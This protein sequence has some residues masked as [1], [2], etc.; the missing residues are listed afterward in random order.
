MQQPCATLASAAFVSDVHLSADDP[1]TANAFLA[2]LEALAG[3]VQ[4]LFVLGDLFDAWI[5]DDDSDAAFAAQVHSAF[6]GL[7]ARGTRVLLMRGNRDFLLD[8]PLPA[9]E[10]T[11]TGEPLGSGE[12]AGANQQAGGGRWPTGGR[13]SASC[14]SQMLAD[15]SV[16]SV[17]STRIAIAHGD[18]L[19]T[20][21]ADYQ[22]WR[23]MV[24]TD[25]WQREFLS[26]PLA[27]RRQMA[28]AL[29]ARSERSKRDK[30][31]QIMDVNADAVA[32]LVRTERVAHLVHGHTHRP[33]RH[34]LRLDGADCERWVLPDWD[35]AAGRGGA[36]VV[37]ALGWRT[38]DARGRPTDAIGKTTD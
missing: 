21:D 11:G 34:R 27:E 25:D 8:A 35:A 30:P 22:R 38:T 26:R 19:C 16:I 4:A 29:R 2:C 9:D 32:A 28:A 18:A 23:S 7:T 12:R 5:G 31:Q 1:A 13:F 36:L 14:G 3:R 17:A 24:R 33:G 20:D 37:D 6:A 10:E 15:P